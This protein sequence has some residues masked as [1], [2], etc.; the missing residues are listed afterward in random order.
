MKPL[1]VCVALLAFSLSACTLSSNAPSAES[2][3]DTASGT[4]A[5]AAQLVSALAGDLVSSNPVGETIL[6]DYRIPMAALGEGE[7]LYL[8]RNRGDTPYRQ[9]VLQFV[10]LPDGRVAQTAYSLTNAEGFADIPQDRAR[11]SELTLADLRLDFTDGCE[12]VWARDPEPEVMWAGV[13]DPASCVIFSKR[14]GYE[15]RIGAETQ[16]TDEGLREAERGFTLAGEQLWGTKPGEWALLSA[17][18]E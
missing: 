14:R 16:V 1:N 13:V 15:I 17:A 8:H 10:D 18:T 3:S 11:L 6:N 7:W 12:Q 5:P 2:A 4:A 9:R